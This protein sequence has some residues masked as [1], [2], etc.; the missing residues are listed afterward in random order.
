MPIVA[1]VSDL[2]FE[3]RLGAV[4]AAVGADVRVVRRAEDARGLLDQADALLVD[5]NLEGGGGLELIRSARTSRPELRI[6]AFVS[7]VQADVARA[8]RDAGADPV[9]ARS[10]FVAR[11]P[12]ILG[13][14]APRTDHGA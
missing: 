1:L 9:L 4:A 12:E 5:A 10:A 11:L 2:I 8:A 3:S 7:H 13:A 14:A 6:V